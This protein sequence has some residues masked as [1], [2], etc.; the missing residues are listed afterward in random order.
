MKK[1]IDEAQVQSVVK[2][3]PIILNNHAIAV[4]HIFTR[5]DCLED[6]W[7]SDCFHGNIGIQ[8]QAAQQM[9]DQL[10][11]WWTPAFLMELR[12]A[13]TKELKKHDNQFGTKFA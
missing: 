1:K 13:I 12:R 6:L 3:F 9:I 8:E 11:D 7:M 4:I 10:Q 2:R 5:H